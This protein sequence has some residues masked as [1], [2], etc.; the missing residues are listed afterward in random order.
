MEKKKPGTLRSDYYGRLF[1]AM[2]CAALIDAGEFRGEGPVRLQVEVSRYPYWDDLVEVR[3]S[4]DSIETI[5]GWQVKNQRTGLDKGDMLKLLR[6][7][8]ESSLDRGH[9]ALHSLEE[10]KKVGP[11]RA[12][13]K[14]CERVRPPNV[15]LRVVLESMST[16]QQRWVE[17][18]RK[19]LKF[20]DDEACLRLFQRLSVEQTATEERLL[21]DALNNLRRWY[22]DPQAVLTKILG[23]IEKTPDEAVL[24]DYPLLRDTVLKGHTPALRRG[25]TFTTLREC[26]LQEVVREYERLPLLKS[27]VSLPGIRLV[28]VFVPPALQL[29]RTSSQALE[30]E[31]GENSS[32]EQEESRS[33]NWRWKQ[34]L[35]QERARAAPSNA[36]D[37]LDWL[38]A[39]DGMQSKTVLIEGAVGSGKS[40]MLE[41]LRYTLAQE[42]LR[43]SDA[44]LPIL[45]DAPDLA[46]G[47][48][49]DAFGRKA[50]GVDDEQL[51]HQEG[52]SRIYLVDGL[53]EVPLRDK[54][55]VS[56]LLDWLRT[57]PGTMA[58][59]LAGRP[60]SSEFP[61]PMATPR[62]R[63]A[64]WTEHDIERFLDKWRQKAPRQVESLGSSWRREPMKSVLS[65][66]LTA[67]FSLLLAEEHPESLRSRTAL[68]SGIC[69]RLFQEWSR[70][71]S[72]CGEAA[73]PS[74]GDVSSVL[75]TLALE[76]ISASRETIRKQELEKRLRK[77][78]PD[79]NLEWMEAASVRFG[80]LVRQGQD[81]YRFVL[82]GLAE[83]LAGHALWREGPHRIIKAARERWA[84]EPVRHAISIAAERAE[85]ADA[86]NLIAQ[87]I[88]TANPLLSR[89]DVEVLGDIR[90]T[91]IA[92]R[93]A[94]DLGAAAQP[95]AAR[96][97]EHLLHYITLP[98]SAWIPARAATEIR[99]LAHVESPCWD[100]L[101]PRLRERLAERS[102]LA[103]WFMNHPADKDW[104]WWLKYLRI[105]DA[106]ARV[107]ITARLARW[108][109][110]KSV[111][112][113][114]VYQLFDD[115]TEMLPSMAVAPT[116][117]GLALRQATRDRHFEQW[118]RPHLL[119]V[120]QE[121]DQLA[122][123]GAALALKPGEANPDLLV[124]AL[125]TLADGYGCPAEVLD[126]LASSPQG[127]AALDSDWGDWFTRS[128]ASDFQRLVPFSHEP[129]SRYMP[130]PHSSL[131]HVLR[132][133]GPALARM[134]QEQ[135]RALGFEDGMAVIGILAEE[136]I[137]HPQ[138]ILSILATAP[139]GDVFFSINT[140]LVLQEAVVRNREV[141]RALLARWEH[142]RSS[143]DADTYPGIALDGLV[144]AGDTDAAQV[145]AAWLEQAISFFRS[146]H[147]ALPLSTKALLHPVVKSVA[148]KLAHNLLKRHTE[149][150]LDDK[151]QSTHLWIG[152]LASGLETL[153][154]A[155]EGDARLEAE[156]VE[157][158]I[159][160]DD[161][162]F[163]HVLKVFQRPPYPVPFRASLM[164]R[165]QR[166]LK[167]PDDE[168]GRF[169][170]AW[171]DWA[172][173][174]GEIPG[175]RPQ[176]EASARS[177]SW[178]SYNAAALLL[179]L[180]NPEESRA[181]SANAAEL[182]PH[183]W[184]PSL[185]SSSDL[186]R[187]AAANP[188]S[189]Y[190]QLKIKL[191]KYE[192]H[193]AVRNTPVF[194][195]AR[196][197]LPS[198]SPED[199]SSLMAQ[200]AKTLW[201]YEQPWIGSDFRGEIPRRPADLFL[202]LCF[203]S[204]VQP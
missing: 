85:T 24:I 45:V 36:V 57:Q 46:T 25:Q 186:L 78:D 15:D 12:L 201:K 149:G 95:I 202:E 196:T 174:A 171:L 154:A 7:L 16:H 161:Y 53:D 97:S 184:S 122:A 153:H 68:F 11:L 159:N 120:L 133:M 26:Y 47:D 27:L 35:R 84:E 18:T 128:R 198:L 49:L 177:K 112:E 175:L 42:A 81:S 94:M 162:S 181:L 163:S 123:G 166:Q 75:Q 29:D 32:V 9:L 1:I 141:A 60:V 76:V 59:V 180:S 164:E 52:V 193:F 71:R 156:L 8:A 33:K 190:K 19:G 203:D 31:A 4:Q 158:A 142:Y 90:T 199:R 40:M 129:A 38:R 83:F 148:H 88:P 82:R 41:H 87:L 183:Y 43:T 168:N 134:S 150:W 121:G 147:P 58:L 194:R 135:R 23:F 51:L 48:W 103:K 109:D 187:L 17:F 10:V 113:A 80:L 63:L 69:E 101:F 126:E 56:S 155:W 191:E 77:M 64:P 138:G 200:L 157:S 151:G 132:A 182:W 66:P 127:R 115:D 160:H 178:I 165:L 39:P 118:T 65:N 204:G 143:G 195:L 13:A 2:R 55:R 5:H 117:A 145:F 6:A 100:A 179:P 14:L 169:L 125:R 74:W 67:T 92:A 119:L 152:N 62:L 124:K 146:P 21:T 140:Q 99:M 167:N 102:D 73:P 86:L 130:L 91:F 72:L 108:V 54:Q 189:W 139:E 70:S 136:A 106:R 185:N 98:V 44:P 20:S 110:E 37:L 111:R 107:V 3:R 137:D 61:V 22:E 192:F 172:E 96:L 173:R 116:E 176:L 188:Q 104:Q 114:L 89:A 105:A 30:E 79:R 131:P 28:D 144:A 170:P 50:P 34:V 93:A 197:L